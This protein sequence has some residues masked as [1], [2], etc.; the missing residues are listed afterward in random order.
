MYTHH[1]KG[2][3]KKEYTGKKEWYWNPTRVASKKW[4]QL[5]H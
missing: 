1:I 4:K 5:E 3:L 2:S